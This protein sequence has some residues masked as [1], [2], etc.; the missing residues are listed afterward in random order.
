MIVVVFFFVVVVVVFLENSSELAI[1]KYNVA[2]CNNDPGINR[3]KKRL[4]TEMS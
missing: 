3:K 1:M 2:S 4:K